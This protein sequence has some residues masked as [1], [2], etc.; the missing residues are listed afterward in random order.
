M[1]SSWIDIQQNTFTRW[2]NEHLKARGYFIKD[3]KTDLSDGLLLVNLL[4]IISGKSLGRYNKHPVVPYQKLE[5]CNIAIQFIQSEGL[6]LVNIGGD[7]IASGRIK[8][9]L[10]KF[11]K[12]YQMILLSIA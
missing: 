9:I 3:L 6:K 11:A 7:D 4:E 10:G 2:C 12:E 5:N 8:L 1:A